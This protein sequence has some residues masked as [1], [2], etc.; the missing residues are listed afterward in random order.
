MLFDRGHSKD[1]PSLVSVFWRHT[2]F[3]LFI[4]KVDQSYRN[5]A[6]KSAFGKK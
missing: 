1:V 2:L 5:G 3:Q 4:P 6:P